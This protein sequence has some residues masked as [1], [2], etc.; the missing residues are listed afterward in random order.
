MTAFWAGPSCTHYLAMLGAEVLHLE[1][2]VRPDGVRLAACPPMSVDQWWEQSPLFTAMNTNKKSVSLNLR[3]ERGQQLMRELIATCDVFVENFTPRVLEQMGLR[4]ED[5]KAINPGIVMVRMPGF[6]LTGPWRDNPAFGHVIENI[7]GLTWLTGYPD[8]GP[9]EPYGGGDS[10]AGM[11]ALVGLLMALDR[12]SRTGAG[13][14]VEATMV[15]A[16]LNVTAEQIVEWSA[17]ER[18]L[19]R[20]GN[21]G[22]VAAPQGLYLTSEV[23]ANDVRDS[24]VAIAVTDEEQWSALSKA[25]GHPEWASD[26]ALATMDGRRE[27]HDE[28]DAAIAEWC[29]SRTGDDIVEELWPLGVPVAK[30]TSTQL[31]P[32][33]APVAARSFFEELEHPLTGTCRYS[34]LPIRF[35][36]GPAR[37]HVRHAPLLGEH[38]DEVLL[39]LGVDAAELALLEER[40]VTGRVP[41]SVTSLLGG[42]PT[43]KKEKSR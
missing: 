38:T 11:H 3:T 24:W 30:V 35:S 32:E 40:G 41:A 33:L 27:H 39:G 7:S 2:T 15:D 29:D 9:F 8:L 12:R 25:V 18:L 10:I 37:H 36:R 14:Q 1:S 28:I 26:P 43:N 6:G 20:D 42:D 31:Q 34:T 23:T 21:R 5:V 16:L 22:P 4:Y 17:N 13:A 19:M